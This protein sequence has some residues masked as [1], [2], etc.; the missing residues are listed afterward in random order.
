[1]SFLFCSYHFI[2]CFFVC[3]YFNHLTSFFGYIFMGRVFVFDLKLINT[4]FVHFCLS[5]TPHFWGVNLAIKRKES[6]VYFSVFSYLVDLVLLANE[7][8]QIVRYIL[9]LIHCS[10]HLFYKT[11]RNAHTLLV[12]HDTHST[13]T[14]TLI[15]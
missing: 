12:L 4:F 6:S 8:S 10:Y 3:L 14:R 1:M 9:R 15:F 7:I 13:L 11:F 2:H 5:I